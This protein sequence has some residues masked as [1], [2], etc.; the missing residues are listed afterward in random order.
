MG[1]EGEDISELLKADISDEPEKE[2]SVKKEEQKVVVESSSVEVVQKPVEVTIVETHQ[3]LNT[4]AT[5][6]LLLHH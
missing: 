5:I 2:Q 3:S 4:K 6:Q 1:E